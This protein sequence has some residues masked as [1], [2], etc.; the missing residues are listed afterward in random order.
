MLFCVVREASQN[1]SGG[2][3]LVAAKKTVF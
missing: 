3:G 2:T 1:G